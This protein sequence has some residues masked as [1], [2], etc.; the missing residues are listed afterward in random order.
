MK[1]L[2]ILIFT[3][4]TACQTSDP[5]PDAGAELDA[6]TVTID[7]APVDAQPSADASLDYCIESCCSVV[8]GDLSCCPNVRR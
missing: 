7:A 6:A 3:I 2:T 8:T 4:L 1:I 5:I